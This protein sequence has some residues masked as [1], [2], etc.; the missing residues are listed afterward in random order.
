LLSRVSTLQSHCRQWRAE[1]Y[2][3]P[4]NSP[5]R[6]LRIFVQN[7]TCTP[8]MPKYVFGLEFGSSSPLR[9]LNFAHVV[10]VSPRMQRLRGHVAVSYAGC[11]KRR[12]TNLP[13]PC[14]VRESPV[15]M[16]ET[17]VHTYKTLSES[18]VLLAAC[19]ANT[20]V[21]DNIRVP[22]DIS[23]CPHLVARR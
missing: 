5:S 18:N 11:V 9:S 8:R 3:A 10:D 2:D 6:A 12:K 4:H 22:Q 13:M 23:R 16:N 15:S 19:G 14:T 7:R 1:F 17:A 21:T 20:T